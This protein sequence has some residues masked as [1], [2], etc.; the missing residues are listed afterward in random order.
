MVMKINNIKDIV[1]PDG[2]IVF[3]TGCTGQDG[4]L[5][6]DY[7]LKETN[8]SI[9][10]GARRLSVEN[11]DNIKHLEAEERF[12]LV[13]F[14]LTDSHSIYKLMEVT[15]PN[16]FINFAAQSF[17]ASS[18]DL[19]RQT[20]QTNS[21][22]VLDCLEAIRRVKPDCRFYNAGSS[23]EFGNV[24]YS[25]Q[26]EKHPA[27][28][29]SPYGASKSAARQLIKV[30]RESYG[31]YAVQGWLFNHEG[32]RRGEEFV[33]RKITK[34]AVRISKEL[35]NCNIP[36]KPIE[37]G[38]VDAKRDW[39]DAEDMVDAVWRMLN[40]D[41]YN[42]KL[43]KE[44]FEEWY[45][46]YNEEKNKKQ[47]TEWESKRIKDYVVSSDENHSIREFVELSF[48]YVGVKDGYWNKEISLTPT[49][50]EG[51]SQ[52]KT[53]LMERFVISRPPFQFTLVKINPKFY[54]PAEVEIL[55]GNSS[56][57]R[58]ELG[59]N[60]KT[61]FDQLVKKMVNRDMELPN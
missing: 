1:R 40:Q 61:S 23:E 39:S 21:T 24:I 56:S 58:K 6:V 2:V 26:D 53:E 31:L 42:E 48:K 55:C 30:Y 37:L 17:V 3:V 15:R 41:K 25:P 12:Q 59:W 51:K 47:M 52:I 38:N 19:A 33:T 49:N 43:N 10:G 20:W 16:Y 35:K 44:H 60:P 32:I 18:W 5:M 4:S 9:I 50:I 8:A 7:L 34:G 29:R 46:L 45:E 11:H 14:D 54:R 36:I 27:R 22:A 57:I 28:P 13:N